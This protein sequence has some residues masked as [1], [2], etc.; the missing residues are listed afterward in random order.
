MIPGKKLAATL[1]VANQRTREALPSGVKGRVF[2]LVENGVDLSLWQSK[3]SPQFSEMDVSVS[4]QSSN[5]LH[6][7]GESHEFGDVNREL[8]PTKFIFMGRLLHWKGLDL[9]LPAF[10]QVIEQL[11]ATLEIIGEGD[12]RDSLTQLAAELGLTDTQQH[13]SG[14]GDRLPAMQFSGWLPQKES[15]L[16]LQA[17]DVLVLPSLFECGGAVVLEAMATGLPVIATNWGGPMDYLDD[18]CGILVSPDSREE[19]IHG[20]TA[21]MLKLA[22]SP[23]LR[24]KMGKAGQ[25]RV[26]NYFDWE[27]KIDTILEIYAETVHR[28]RMP[29]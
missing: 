21:A 17:A 3:L 15:A 20:L 12:A 7:S 23:T 9:L 16:R 19:F 18:T 28:V 29:E 22:K 11:P 8:H 2:E 5:E 6:R 13:S 24:E 26:L 27:K 10:K 4:I 14:Y 25:H 1:L